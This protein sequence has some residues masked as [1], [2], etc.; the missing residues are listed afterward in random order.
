M[1]SH[2]LL[3]KIVIPHLLSVQE[4]SIFGVTQGIAGHACFTS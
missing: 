2:A 1:K 3:S 4:R